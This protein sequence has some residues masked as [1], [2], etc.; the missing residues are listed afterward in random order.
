MNR[1][2]RANPTNEWKAWTGIGRCKGRDGE[3]YK[4]VP[5]ATMEMKVG[6]NILVLQSSNYQEAIKKKNFF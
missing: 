6:M 5:F 1:Q 2:N 3:K 4:P